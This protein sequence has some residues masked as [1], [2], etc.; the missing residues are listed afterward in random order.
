MGIPL[1]VPYTEIPVPPT[2]P[3]PSVVKRD[4]PILPV[5]ISYQDKTTQFTF[6]SVIDSGA[7]NCIFPAVI[8]RQIGIPIESGAKLQT[9][10]VGGGG[11]AYFHRIVVIF[12]IQGNPY[13]FNCYAGF[14]TSMDQ[15]GVGLLGRHGFFDLF[16]RVAFNNAGRVVELTPR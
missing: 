8:G 12:A 15:V 4:Y 10:G 7:D 1:V 5:A 9:A 14:M 13:R 6:F 16:E 11:I 2:E 3:F